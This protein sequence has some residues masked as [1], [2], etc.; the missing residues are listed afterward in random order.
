MGGQSGGRGHGLPGQRQ[1][2]RQ[3]NGWPGTWRGQ[4]AGGCGRAGLGL[5]PGSTTLPGCPGIP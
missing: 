2:E 1:A 3:R 4:R 5:R